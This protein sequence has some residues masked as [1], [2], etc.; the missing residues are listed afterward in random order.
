MCARY[1]DLA[2]NPRKPQF[3]AR[4]RFVHICDIHWSHIR[5]QIEL[6]EAANFDLPIA[7]TDEKYCFCR[8]F[9]A[10]ITEASPTFWEDNSDAW[11]GV[12][13]V[14]RDLLKHIYAQTSLPADFGT[15]VSVSNICGG[16][17][18]CLSVRREINLASWF[19]TNASKFTS[20]IT[21]LVNK[22]KCHC[23][24]GGLVWRCQ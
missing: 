20:L 13:N 15:R 10:A 11:S 21:P 6:P 18:L 23:R 14:S 12:C 24:L 17:S 7:R 16:I 3:S 19:H 22:Y 9:A 4:E 5:G 1:D 8:W 2:A